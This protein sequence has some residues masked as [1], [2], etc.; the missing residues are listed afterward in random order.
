MRYGTE[1]SY[2]ANIGSR[3]SRAQ[4]WRYLYDT[5]Q[6]S[7][8]LKHG[9]HE[10]LWEYGI[11][12][13]HVST[14]TAQHGW[15]NHAHRPKLDLSRSTINTGLI[16]KRHRGSCPKIQWTPK[17]KAYYHCSEII[18]DGAARAGAWQHAPAL[19]DRE[20]FYSNTRSKCYHQ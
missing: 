11:G 2:S 16:S 14:L 1:R 20:C 15:Y 9:C 18:G 17:N 6:C 7:S 10:G 8:N 3:D 12:S 19:V 5:V 13:G 4:R